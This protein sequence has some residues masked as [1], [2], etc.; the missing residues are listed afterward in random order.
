[1]V[2]PRL[3]P[4][5]DFGDVIFLLVLNLL[6]F[7]LP[8]FMLGDG[9][10][11]WHLVTGQS[12]LETHRVPTQDIIS[13]TFPGAPWVAYEWLFDLFA[14][15][16]EKFA[17][18]NGLVV[19]CSSIIALVMLLVYERC[20]RVGLNFPMAAF[21]VIVGSLASSV[22][23]LA[24]PHIFSILGVYIFAT[25]LESFQQGKLSKWKMLG[26]LSACTAVWVNLHPGFLLGFAL[27]IIYLAC[28]LA[29][30]ILIKRDTGGGDALTK[31]KWFGA[32]FVSLLIASMVNPYGA[33]LFGYIG[34]YL[35]N[36]EVL[37]ATNEFASP[38][39]H[40]QVQQSCLEI[41]FLLVIIGLAMTAKRPSLPQLMSCLAFGHLA[42]SGIRNAPV[43]V[44]VALP[45]I[46]DLFSQ[47]RLPF[48]TGMAEATPAHWLESLGQRFRRFCEGFDQN[49]EA[50]QMHILPV[51]AVVVL[52]IASANS[53]SLCG[54]RILDCTPSPSTM[55]TKTLDYIRDN[56]LDPKQGF[57][58]DNWGGYIRYRLGI[59]VFIDDRLDFYGKNF[60][61]EYGMIVQLEPGWAQL[62]D[63]H[64]IGWILFPKNNQLSRQLKEDRR[65][66][67]V[68][69][70]Q[71]ADLFERVN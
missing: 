31:A 48:S 29:T 3:Y 21:L 70:D 16:T 35:Q 19:A 65:W 8:H 54:E 67:L 64:K 5:P 68:C 26:I 41:I 28:A 43:F 45:F 39:F 6:V 23:W 20:R 62:L 71:A 15:L 53:G 60:Y 12:I 18:L 24:R 10:T 51:V 69:E 59:P 55:P 36:S 2:K 37:H 57:N 56:H 58:Y 38:V 66:K 52:M 7:A 47:V 4:L 30:G 17:G 11:G 40:G 22:H 42:L 27:T 34:H 63:K 46:A 32:T 13:Y 33:Q 1:V 61:F 44:I 9:S 49:E 50:C 14:A 25:S